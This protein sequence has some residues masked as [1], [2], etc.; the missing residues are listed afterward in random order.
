MTTPGDGRGGGDC[1]VMVGAGVGGPTGPNAG[2]SG[3]FR[4]PS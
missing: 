3:A 2:T 4:V 1:E